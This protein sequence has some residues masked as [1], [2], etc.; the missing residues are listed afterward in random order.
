MRYEAFLSC[1]KV[2]LPSFVCK[3]TIGV[4]MIFVACYSIIE[5]IFFNLL[6]SSVTFCG[7]FN[8]MR[9]MIISQFII[10]IYVT[11]YK[12]FHGPYKLILLSC[13]GH[14][15]NAGVTNVGEDKRLSRH[16]TQPNL[17]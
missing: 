11:N 5:H 7:N 1:Q 15:T 17:F 4:D 14:R 8:T 13:Y 3:N 6:C 10:K 16:L 9:E 12:Y 2:V